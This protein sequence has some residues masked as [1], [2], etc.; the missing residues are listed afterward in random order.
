MPEARWSAIPAARSK[1]PALQLRL[2]LV[3]ALLGLSSAAGLL[4][5]FAWLNVK[6]ATATPSPTA[7]TAAETVATDYLLGIPTPVPVAP[8][9]QNTTGAQWTMNQSL[10]SSGAG[11]RTIY[12]LVLDKSGSHPYGYDLSVYGQAP[13]TIYVETDHFVAVT[14]LGTFDVAVPMYLTAAGPELAA[15]PSLSP[16]TPAATPGATALDYHV[17]PG[18]EAATPQMNSAAQAWAQAFTTSAAAVATVVATPGAD[19]NFQYLPGFSL[20]SATALGA[21]PG[22]GSDA[23]YVY[24]RERLVVRSTSANGVT[25]TMDYDLMLANTSLAIN[26]KVVA[27]GPAG[28]A[29][30]LI[31][32]QTNLTS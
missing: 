18:F 19:T 14:N 21:V 8:V 1:A 24:L 20:V 28:S 5:A 17:E 9:A 3:L 32:Y 22:V 15:L 11:T 2:F 26:Y 23:G 10:G 7:L 16:Y 25:L 31:P 27:W 12:S 30:S 4:S 29:A 13:S 6:P